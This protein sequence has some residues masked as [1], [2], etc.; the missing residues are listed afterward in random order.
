VFGSAPHTHVMKA[1]ED[2]SAEKGSIAPDD[3]F[4]PFHLK[5]YWAAL[6]PFT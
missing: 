5:S 1:E 3:C 6:F 4:A 2:G